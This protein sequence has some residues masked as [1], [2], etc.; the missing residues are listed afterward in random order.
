MNRIVAERIEKA[1]DEAKHAVKVATAIRGI[2][3]PLLRRKDFPS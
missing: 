3:R 1:E 2:L